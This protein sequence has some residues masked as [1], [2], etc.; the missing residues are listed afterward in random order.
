MAPLSSKTESTVRLAF[1]LVGAIDYYLLLLV[2]LLSN[3]YVRSGYDL[4]KEVDLLMILDSCTSST[5][6]PGSVREPKIPYG[7]WGS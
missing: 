5:R 1:D 4:L 6:I 3:S 7:Q 2:S